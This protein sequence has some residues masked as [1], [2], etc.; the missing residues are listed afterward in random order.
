MKKT[1]NGYVALSLLL[2]AVLVGVITL[3]RH[4][5]GIDAGFDAITYLSCPDEVLGHH[6]EIVIVREGDGL[7]VLKYDYMYD[8]IIQRGEP[9]DLSYFSRVPIGNSEELPFNLKWEELV[10]AGD[11]TI[12]RWW[13]ETVIRRPIWWREALR[14]SHRFKSWQWS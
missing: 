11:F 4:K 1:Q 12:P 10:P 7:A 8:N 13:S 3:T 9:T 14:S 2:I 6:E 5:A